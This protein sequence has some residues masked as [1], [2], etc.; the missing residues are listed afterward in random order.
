MEWKGLFEWSSKYI[1]GT[2]PS[3]FTPLAKKDKEWLEKVMKE[4]T[5]DEAD[6][7][8]QIIPVLYK[9]PS[10]APADSTSKKGK[11]SKKKH[12]DADQSTEAELMEALEEL[13]ELIDIHQRNST[14]LDNLG[15]FRVLMDVMFNCKYEKVRR[16][17]M[18]VFS[19][20]VQNNVEIQEKAHQYG[21]LQLM[22]QYVKETS[23][24]NKEQVIGALSSLIRTSHT[25]LK[26]DFFSE[27]KGLDWIQEIIL[28]KNVSKRTL[29]KV[30]FMLYD[31]IVKETDKSI[32][33]VL[34][35]ENLIKDYIVEHKKMIGAMLK[36]LSYEEE[37]AED[38]YSDHVLREFVLNC[39]GAIFQ[40]SE[41][42]MTED[43]VEYLNWCIQRIEQHVGYIK[44][45]KGDQDVADVLIKEHALIKNIL[46]KSGDFLLVH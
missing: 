1:D 6:R 21:G 30:Y 7:M 2:K 13:Q 11:K 20:S 25:A 35:K 38:L 9:H 36:T 22:H 10:E 29:K 33:T 41:K 34:Y 31:L 27:M 23:D 3:N 14:N 28:D 42:S 8:S 24:K 37:K 17:A 12:S 4:Y 45:N 32:D 43:A 16:L 5:Y 46:E 40:Y 26:A 39:V 15:G 44:E 18:L 19:A